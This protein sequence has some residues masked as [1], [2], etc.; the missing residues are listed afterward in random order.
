MRAEENRRERAADEVALVPPGIGQSSICAASARRNDAEQRCARVGYLTA[1]A[2]SRRS[3]RECKRTEQQC[4][5][6]IDISVATV[7]APIVPS[8]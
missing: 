6:E 4:K 2:F 5:R 7:Q 8:A 1:D 3:K